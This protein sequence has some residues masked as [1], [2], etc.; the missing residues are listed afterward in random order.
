M[1]TLYFHIEFSKNCCKVHACMCTRSKSTLW[2]CLSPRNISLFWSIDD[3]SAHIKYQLLQL[4]LWVPYYQFLTVRCYVLSISILLIGIVNVYGW[5]KHGPI[6]FLSPSCSRC[7][8]AIAKCTEHHT[9]YILKALPVPRLAHIT[10]HHHTH[11]SSTC[12]SDCV[13]ISH[14]E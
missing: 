11:S 10:S 4:L 5:L 14:R 13:M 7:P 1:E 8:S 6:R 2:T 3:L 12:N 9:N